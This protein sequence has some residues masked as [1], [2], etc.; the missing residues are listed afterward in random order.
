MGGWVLRR[1]AMSYPETTTHALFV[2]QIG[3]SD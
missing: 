2:N 1:F 3:K